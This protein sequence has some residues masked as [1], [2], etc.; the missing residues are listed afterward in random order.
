M[1]GAITEPFWCGGCRKILV[2]LLWSVLNYHFVKDK[3]NYECGIAGT[4]RIRSR[5][6]ISVS[7]HRV[8]ISWTDMW[9]WMPRML[10]GIRMFLWSTRKICL[11]LQIYTF[12]NCHDTLYMALLHLYRYY[13][14]LLCKIVKISMQGTC[15]IH[16][17]CKFLLSINTLWN[18]SCFLYNYYGIVTSMW[19]LRKDNMYIIVGGKPEAGKHLILGRERRLFSYYQLNAHFLHSITIPG[20]S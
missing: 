4:F 11:A 13:R 16:V 5:H 2:E 3:T 9:N 8:L 6:R 20:Y 18:F 1:W 12:L 19:E 14:I 17:T 7:A 10:L 15:N